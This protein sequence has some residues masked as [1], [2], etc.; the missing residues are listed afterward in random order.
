MTGIP[1]RIVPNPG[2]PPSPYPPDGF[3]PG[4][5]WRDPVMDIDGLEAWGI[6][7]PN[8]TVW[9]TTVEASGGGGR[10]TVTGDPP[11]ITVTP[12]IWDKTPGRDSAGQA[13][14]WHGWIRDGALV[15]A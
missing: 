13:R 2:E 4:D 6:V 15:P 7:L 8:N 10:W 1:L 9:Y 12:S 14:E 5:M 11:N 3:A